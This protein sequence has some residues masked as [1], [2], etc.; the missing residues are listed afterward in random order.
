MKNA[1]K[2]EYLLM[3]I[4]LGVVFLIVF[5]SIYD[6]RSIRRNIHNDP[7]YA[8]ATIDKYNNPSGNAQKTGSSLFISFY[9]NEKYIK[10]TSKVPLKKNGEVIV[11]GKDYKGEKYIVIYNRDDSDE[12]ILLFNYPIKNEFDFDRYMKEFEKNPPVLE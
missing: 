7:A 2:K 6:R 5:G 8:I 4:L 1:I 9:D 3:L 10:T 11:P 12:C